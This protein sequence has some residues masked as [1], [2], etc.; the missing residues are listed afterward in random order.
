MA[1]IR[2]LPLGLFG[3]P[4]TG[5]RLTECNDK[6]KQAYKSTLTASSEPARVSA[7]GGKPKAHPRSATQ[8]FCN[9]LP[10]S[11]LIVLHAVYLIYPDHLYSILATVPGR[12]AVYDPT[13]CLVSPISKHFQQSSSIALP[14]SATEK[15]LN[16]FPYAIL[17]LYCTAAA[18][19]FASELG[20]MAQ[21]DPILLT[22]LLRLKVRSVPRGTNGGV[23][24]LGIV[25]SALGASIVCGV[26]VTLTPLCIRQWDAGEQVTL[27]LGAVAIGIVGAILDSLLGAWCQASIVDIPTGKIV[28]NSGGGKVSFKKANGK[29]EVAGKEVGRVEEKRKMV[30]GRDILS[31]NGV[32]LVTGLVMAALTTIGIMLV[33]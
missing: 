3:G 19:T 20:I 25:A 15:M 17:A 26:F 10:A 4:Q 18:D 1:C 16:T 7:S 11:F 13:L 2:K 24:L 32:N 30:A 6:L 23:T 31:N 28:E 8:V 12:T 21:D 33:S 27:A 5:N 22:E 9:S 29:Y 14:R